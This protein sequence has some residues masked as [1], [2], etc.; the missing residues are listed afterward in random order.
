MTPTQASRRARPRLPQAVA[1]IEGG[2]PPPFVIATAVVRAGA[3]GWE[4]G[5]AIRNFTGDDYTVSVAYNTADFTAADAD[6]FLR[7]MRVSRECFSTS[8][9]HRPSLIARAG[10]CGHQ[11]EISLAPWHGLAF[12]EPQEAAPPRCV[13]FLSDPGWGGEAPADI[14]RRQARGPVRGSFWRIDAATP[15]AAAGAPPVSQANAN[16]AWRCLD[17]WFGSETESDDGDD[18]WPL[19]E[20]R[21]ACLTFRGRQ[22]DCG[23]PDDGSGAS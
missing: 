17:S 19:P 15:P 11:Y 1:G 18:A 10:S 5:R 16:R 13:L 2:I 22:H 4:D 14:R 6:R 3:L 23:T 9:A 20:D 12:A 8:L 21:E 7:F